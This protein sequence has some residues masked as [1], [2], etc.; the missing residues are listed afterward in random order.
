MWITNVNI[1]TKLLCR[2]HNHWF[3]VRNFPVKKD[4]TSKIGRT[5]GEEGMQK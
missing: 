5:G 3:S 2:Q 1:N 4:A